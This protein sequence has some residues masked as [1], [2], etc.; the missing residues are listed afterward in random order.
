VE[1]IF[2]LVLAGTVVAKLSHPLGATNSPTEPKKFTPFLELDYDLVLPFGR[3]TFLGFSLF[4]K[5]SHV[6]FYI[7]LYFTYFSNIL[8]KLES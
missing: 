7:K 8:V 1:H 3:P 5:N 2:L 6:I 4:P